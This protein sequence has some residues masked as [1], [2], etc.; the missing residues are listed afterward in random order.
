MRELTQQE[1]D[2]APKWATEYCVQYQSIRY[3]NK[4]HYQWV[5][6]ESS[7]KKGHFT[8]RS[9][10]MTRTI[11]GK[12]FDITEYKFS[13]PEI[14]ATQFDDDEVQLDMVDGSRPALLNKRDAIA[15]AKHFKL[16][17]SDLL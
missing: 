17:A 14:G 15:L 7:E 8:G 16:T 1:I 2:N 5:D 12:E 10:L 11:P 6:A 13:D 3:S 4:T 9:I